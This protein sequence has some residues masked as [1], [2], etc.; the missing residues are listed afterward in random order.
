[1][2]LPKLEIEITADPSKAV[3]GLDVAGDAVEATGKRA[4]VASGRVNK[5]SSSF[6]GLQ[7]KSR[8]LGPQLSQVAQ[9]FT[10]TG[11][12]GQAVAVQAADIGLA[13]GPMGIAIGAVAGVALP[14]LI[15][16]MSGASDG[17]EQLEESLDIVKGIVDGFKEPLDILTAD[18]SE[19]EEEF[20]EAAARAREWAIAQAE[21]RVGVAESALRDNVIILRDTTKAYTELAHAGGR[22][23]NEAILLE[24]SVS[25]IAKDFSI[26]KTEAEGF[27]LIL[28]DLQ[29]ATEFNAQADALQRMLN[30]LKQAGVPLNEMP[31]DMQR[32]VDEMIELQN[33]TARATTLMDTLGQAAANVSIGGPDAAQTAAQ[34]GGRAIDGVVSTL[35]VGGRRGGGRGGG[36]RTPRI[37]ALIRSLQTEREVIDAW[38]ADSLEKLNNAN[39]EELEALGGH[40]EAKL[41]LEQEYQE[42]LQGLRTGYNGDALTQA[43]TF[44]GDMATALQG[45]NEKLAA[46]GEKFA[47]AEAVVNAIRAYSQVAADP[48]LPWFAKIPAAISVAGAVTAAASSLGGGSGGSAAQSASQAQASSQGPLDVRLSGIGPN[49]LITVSQLSSLFDR[50][51]DESQD[52]GLNVSFAT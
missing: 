23:R 12:L 21:I 41:R 2:A 25:R 17:A 46:I 22:Y 1:M 45:G 8:Q 18:I 4:N 42:R 9:Q 48:T 13:F 20:G 43:G 37:D 35:S 38:R 5:V 36:A 24:E 44:F 40:N 28:Q 50:L 49:D 27:R 15:A 47:K 39:A 10:A 14:S 30:F 19:L 32:A 6:S 29:G 16:A 52:R 11:Q 51:M 7:K 34:P 3:K 33:A 26:S 31:E